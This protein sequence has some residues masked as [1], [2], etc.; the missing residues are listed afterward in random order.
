M[1]RTKQVSRKSHGAHAKAI[2]TEP[3]AKTGVNPH[4]RIAAGSLSKAS[5]PLT[6][7]AKKTSKRYRPGAVAL[8]QIRRY[9]KSTDLLLRKAPFARIVREIAQT[10]KSDLRFHLSALEALQEAAEAYLVGLFE[11][12]NLCAIHA[13]RVT[14]MPKDFALARRIRRETL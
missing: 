2:K 9:Q 11:D 1:A 4:H 13:R 7:S 5:V 6:K 12:A 3:G 14:V 10:F 8:A